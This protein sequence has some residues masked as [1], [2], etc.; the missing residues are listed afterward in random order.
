M[1]TPAMST[2]TEADPAVSL[3]TVSVLADGGRIRV[4]TSAA[5]P[6]QRP[7]IRPMLLSADATTARVS[8]V[9]EG[10][11]L[12]AGD[13]VRIR[14]EVGPGALLDLQEP[15]GTVAYDMRGGN[16]TW[17]V[18]V[19]LA[20]D[21][22]LVWR[23]EPFVVADGADVR[24]RTRIVVSPGSRLAVRE[25]L[26]LG[27]HGEQGG[28]IRQALTVEEP[29]GSPVLVEELD[30]EAGASAGLLGGH[31]V[32]GSVLALG[33]PVR[34]SPDRFDLEAGGH[35]L[36]RLTD[37]A[38]TAHDR[39]AWDQMVREICSCTSNSMPLAAAR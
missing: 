12:L 9:P 13:A 35:L 36:R 8:L 34:P 19:S 26:V 39:A 11:L 10:A 5:G 14:V 32:V 4:R 17:D 22:A 25:T 37:E 27:R 38:H 30:V 31:R 29:D 24:R 6:A 3:T 7:L 21:A 33:V 1:R 18:E 23:G 16:A 28:R 15:G 20:E 2:H